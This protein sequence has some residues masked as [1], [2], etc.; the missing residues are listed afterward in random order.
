MLAP[1]T[2]LIS[3]KSSWKGRITTLRIDPINTNGVYELE[4]ITFLKNP[5]K[6]IETYIDGVYY[7]SHYQSKA[8]DGEIYVSFEPHRDFHRLLN[9]YIEWDED[10]R[11]LMTEYD[12]KV[13]YWTENS[14]TVKHDGGDIKLSKP[15]EFYDNL[16]YVPMSVLSKITGCKYSFDEET[17]NIQTL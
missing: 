14:D 11:T 5:K 4:S 16:P 13:Y 2:V 7:D 8:E 17:L 12:G 1:E 9:M 6:N 10:T 15:L 3:K